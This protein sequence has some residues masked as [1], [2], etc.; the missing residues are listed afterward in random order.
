[1]VPIKQGRT[2]LSKY[3]SLSLHNIL[4]VVAGQALG[5]H[6]GKPQRVEDKALAVVLPILRDGEID[7]GYV[8][9]PEATKHV[10]VTD[11]GSIHKVNL[12]NNHDQ[13]VFVRSGS[14]FAGM[15]TQSRTITRS[16]VLFPGKEVS[17]DA[18]CVHQS[19]S[20]RSGAPFAYHGTISLDVEKSVYGS[21]FTPRDQSVYWQ[22][23]QA[24]SLRKAQF[25]DLM[26][27]R[28]PL[29]TLRL[30]DAMQTVLL[31]R[32]NRTATTREL[33]EEIARR[34]LYVRRDG[35]AAAAGQ[36]GAR[37][38]RYNTMFEVFGYG[39]VRLREEHLSDREP[40]NNRS[41][42]EARRASVRSSPQFEVSEARDNFVAD[43]TE[44]TAN[45]DEL[46]SK[47]KLHEHQVGISLITDRGVETIELFEADLSWAALHADSVKRI[48]TGFITEENESVFEYKPE[49]AIEQVCRV[50]ALNYESN[51]IFE[52]RA[53][54]Q[55]LVITGLTSAT[56]VGEIVEFGGTV[57]HLSLLKRAA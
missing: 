13:P 30:H 22:N 43:D 40:P 20:I 27:D 19:H 35:K 4:E 18:R 39:I 10:L 33:S 48:G 3:E 9:Y 16:A 32:P 47:V 57:I 17:L 38:R 44:F 5:F 12:K 45:L 49:K 24:S 15:D 37:A 55:S 8:T 31:A 29:A 14:V 25:S 1:M 56:H 53:G 21:G 54:D 7:R 52:H 51:T 26:D 23:V 46:L 28:D 41:H 2:D 34:G 50:L 6:F 42:L 11:S 36:I